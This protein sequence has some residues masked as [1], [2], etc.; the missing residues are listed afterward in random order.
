MSSEDRH[1]ALTQHFSALWEDANGQLVASALIAQ[2]G[3]SLTFLVHPQAQGQG[4]EAEILA[5]GLAQMQLIAQN[6]GSPRELWCRC[7]EGE[8]ERR[9][10]LEATGFLSIFERDLRLAHALAQPLSPVSLP[11]G[12]CLKLGVKQ[13][14]LMPIRNCIRPPLMV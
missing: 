12:F 14:S 9:S 5:W 6:R 10:V 8:Q 1:R 3:C 11:A 2:P 7:H 13:G 4:V